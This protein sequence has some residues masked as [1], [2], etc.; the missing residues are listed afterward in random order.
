[1]KYDYEFSGEAAKYLRRL[2]ARRRVQIF[3]LLDQLC[4][5]PRDP[6]I[7]KTLSGRWEGTRRSRVGNLRLIY[8]ILEDRLLINVV[9]LGPRGDIY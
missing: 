9:R 7:S 3:L 5:N 2:E 8:E 4:A 6:L 1:L